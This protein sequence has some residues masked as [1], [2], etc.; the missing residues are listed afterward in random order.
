MLM[1][2]IARWPTADGRSCPG[3]GQEP[4]EDGIQLRNL[5]ARQRV[6]EVLLDA[7]QMHL[8][9][10]LQHLPSPF[11]QPDVVH[12]PV[13]AGCCRAYRRRGRRL[14]ALLSADITD[15]RTTNDS[16]I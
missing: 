8:R 5:I 11:G 2:C 12:A 13:A 9:R 7:A 6:D 15:R 14:C 10:P 4:G 16:L 1:S 3:S